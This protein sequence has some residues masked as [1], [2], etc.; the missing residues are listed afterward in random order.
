MRRSTK[1]PDAI[2]AYYIERCKEGL[3]VA[4]WVRSKQP[5]RPWQF[6]PVTGCDFHHFKSGNVRR[7]H[8]FG[9]GLCGW[10]HRS[11]LHFGCTNNEMRETF[12]PS[13]MDGSRL[14]HDFY[15]SDDEL[16]AVQH[17]LNGCAL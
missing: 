14:F 12:G 3:C 17:E 15:G 8:L 1:K 7:G 11:L 13:L 6:F 16:L 4:C 10:H 2:E 9:V 5:D